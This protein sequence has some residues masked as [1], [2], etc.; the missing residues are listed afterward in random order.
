MFIHV[1]KILLNNSRKFM[2]KLQWST[3]QDFQHAIE[4][5]VQWSKSAHISTS[6]SDKGY[7]EDGAR[8]EASSG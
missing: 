6:R 1:N 2:E 3:N 4:R 8:L 5:S 7:M